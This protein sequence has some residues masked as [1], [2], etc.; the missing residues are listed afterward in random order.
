MLRCRAHRRFHSVISAPVH[1]GELLFY[2][3]IHHDKTIIRTRVHSGLTARRENN[4][5]QAEF[6]GGTTEC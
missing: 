6:N 4:Y 5:E 2:P 1:R 3:V